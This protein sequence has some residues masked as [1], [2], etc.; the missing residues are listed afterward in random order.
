MPLAVIFG[1]GTIGSETAWSLARTSLLRDIVLVDDAADIA[2]GRALDISQAGPIEGFGTRVHATADPAVVERA[3]V[4]VVA[5]RA[6]TPC[7]EIAGE[8]GLDTLARIAKTAPGTP[9]VCAGVRQAW[10]IEHAAIEAG[11]GAG[12][13][14]GS[15]PIAL[16]AVLRLLVA[17]RA[18][19]SAADVTLR[20]VG[21]PPDSMLVLWEAARI[22]GSPAEVV[23]DQRTRRTLAH[24]IPRLWDLEACALAAAA[25]VL[26]R[27]L[28]TASSRTLSCLTVPRTGL[29]AGRAVVAPVRQRSGVG[30]QL[31]MDVCWPDLSGQPG[32]RLS[33][34]M[35]SDRPGAG[36]AGP[37]S[38]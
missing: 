16:E 1:A 33:A 35:G 10:L 13:I 29:G 23:L 18:G 28:L 25:T 31:V 26:C 4:T 24:R 38:S 9:I 7:D 19:V 30:G 17:L 20:A 6:L 21:R 37:A 34:V 22:A 15:A 36:P 3:A 14:L 5:D 32:V 8:A 27:T 12:Q 2:R 11:V